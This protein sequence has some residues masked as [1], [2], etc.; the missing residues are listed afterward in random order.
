MRFNRFFFSATLLAALTLPATAVQINFTGGT[1]TL[2]DGTTQTTD[3]L[4]VWQN[5]DY[6]EEGGFRLDF[7]GNA[8]NPFSAIVGNYYDA[9]NDVIHSHWRTGDFGE[10]DQIKVTKIDGTAFDLNYF[11]LTSNTDTGGTAAS[12]NER[13]LIHASVDGVTS[14]ASRLLPPEDW[15]FPARQIFLGSE[16]DGIKAF[17]FTAE[18]SIDCFGMDNFFINEPAPP[19]VPEPGSLALFGLGLAGIACRKFA[20]WM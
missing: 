4:V 12:G 14:N 16:F 13:A 8:A 11:V 15:G 10:I 6:Y 1:V 7:I 20:K 3:N 19:E 5:V 17:W 9:G 18:N 2:L